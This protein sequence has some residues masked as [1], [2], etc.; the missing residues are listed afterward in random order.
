MMIEILAQIRGDNFE[1]GI[2]LRNDKVIEAAPIVA[3]MK[4]GKWTRQQVRDYCKK[5]RWEISV[6]HEIRSA[7]K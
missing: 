5:R 1:A 3:Y 4:R 2:V 7:S 6:V